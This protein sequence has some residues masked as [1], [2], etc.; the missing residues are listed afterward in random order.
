MHASCS[1]VINT[2]HFSFLRERERKKNTYGGACYPGVVV[3]CFNGR[4]YSNVLIELLSHMRSDRVHRRHTHFLRIAIFYPRL[5]RCLA[6]V[7]FPEK[8]S[9]CPVCPAGGREEFLSESTVSEISLINGCYANIIRIWHMFP[10][11]LHFACS[12]SLVQQCAHCE[13]KVPWPGKTPL[14]MAH[15]YSFIEKFV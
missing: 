2:V 6:E 10:K 3:I 12:F 1:V 13:V 8:L 14:S 11:L 4:E 5:I 15:V 9:H 7:K